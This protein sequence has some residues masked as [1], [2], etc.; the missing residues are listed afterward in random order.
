[1]PIAKC[2]PQGSSAPPVPGPEGDALAYFDFSQIAN[3]DMKATGTYSI[4]ITGGSTSATSATV[5]HFKG[6]TAFGAND[7]C[8]VNSGNLEFNSNIITS[9]LG[10]SYWST[11]PS[12]FL[13]IDM[14][15]ISSLLAGDP[16]FQHLMYEM[17]VELEPELVNGVVAQK[18]RFAVLSM[19]F[20]NRLDTWAAGTITRPFGA[21]AT[22]QNSAT[23]GGSA[24][25]GLH[26]FGFRQFN[27]SS[28]NS[29]SWQASSASGKGSPL[30]SWFNYTETKIK[31]TYDGVQGTVIFDNGFAKVRG[32]HFHSSVFGSTYTTNNQWTLDPH[33]GNN[34]LWCGFTFM[35]SS[36]SIQ[37]GETPFRIKKIWIHERSLI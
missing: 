12:S 23:W 15:S 29:G 18:P 7:I 22:I 9:D 10:L 37:A 28:I 6:D 8:R 24:N 34:N 16:A 33:A 3:I 26:Y 32:A 35:R 30:D 5:K 21:C 13:A 2:F 20:W 17:T 4:P 27:R 36:Y 31:T 25:K 11:T 14:S 1:M 19:G